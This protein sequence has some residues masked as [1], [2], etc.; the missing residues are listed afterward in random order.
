MPAVFEVMGVMAADTLRAT[1]EAFSDGIHVHSDPPTG[2]LSTVT[3]PLK[4][5]EAGE[6]A[7]LIAARQI[8]HAYAGRQLVGFVSGESVEASTTQRTG[9]HSRAV[10][11]DGAAAKDAVEQWMD[12]ETR[13]AVRTSGRLV[14]MAPVA[15]WKTG[16]KDGRLLHMIFLVSETDLR[17]WK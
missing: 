5:T 4:A 17:A 15:S 11:G 14:R 3:V 2:L 6:G 10:S 12:V 16:E 8:A 1:P 13:I 7:A 9:E